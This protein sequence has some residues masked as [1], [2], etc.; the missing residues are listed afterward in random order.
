MLEQDLKR[1]L[2]PVNITIEKLVPTNRRLLDFINEKAVGR[3]TKRSIYKV[4]FLDKAEK[5]SY[6]IAN[7]ALVEFERNLKSSQLGKAD[8]EELLKEANRLI[9]D[10]KQKIEKVY[11]E[12]RR[13]VVTKEL[14]NDCLKEHFRKIPSMNEA[15]NDA[16]S[17]EI[18]SMAIEE[19]NKSEER[20]IE[21]VEAQFDKL[22]YIATALFNIAAANSAPAVV[23]K[24][25]PPAPEK[26]PKKAQKKS[27]FDRFF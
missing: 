14:R 10:A 3:G 6:Q 1:I 27:F 12:V 8:E 24:K 26:P 5:S 22:N 4:K 15:Q 25:I 9:D 21:D 18:F 20:N 11:G 7:V 2:K 23:E 13:Y 17:K 19:V 16:I